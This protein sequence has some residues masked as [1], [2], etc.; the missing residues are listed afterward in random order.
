MSP[1]SW[2][3]RKC[4]DERIPFSSAHEYL[5]GILGTMPCEE[6]G[7]CSAS[8]RWKGLTQDGNPTVDVIH[9]TSALAHVP[10][11]IEDAN[12]IFDERPDFTESFNV[13]E[14]ERFRRSMNSLLRRR[15]DEDL[16]W[17][18]LI[19]SVRSNDEELLSKF[20]QVFDDNL[21][22]SELFG[23][24]YVHGRTPA[25]GRAMSGGMN[26]THNR[27][28][29]H[30]GR[31][32]VVLDEG[33]T[34]RCILHRPA[35][36]SARC[37]IGLDAFPA[38][39]MWELNTGL[40]LR[41]DSV[42][43]DEVRRQ[44]RRD[45]R[46]L[47]V[48]QVGTAVNYVTSGWKSP[49]QR[50]KS[51]AIIGEL[52]EMYGAEFRTA[53][54]SK[55]VERSV[56]EILSEAGIKGAETLYY[57][58]LRSNN[59]FEGERV[60]LL[61]GVIDPGDEYVLDMLALAGLEARPETIEGNRAQGRGFEGPDSRTARGFL[62]AIRESS[63]AQGIGRYARNPDSDSSGATVYVWTNVIPRQ[64]VDEVVSGVGSEVTELMRAIE[65]YIREKS[66]VT[67]R[68]VQNGI[69]V[70]EDHTVGSVSKKHVL[71]VFGRLEEQGI[72]VIHKEAGAYGADLC[73]YVSGELEREVDLGVR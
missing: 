62:D 49:A 2:F 37:V 70:P 18:S 9:A 51:K 16:T 33:N 45:E 12:V 20:E 48:R 41:S 64:L 23:E 52:R 53:I 39:R 38:K 69:E 40:S 50:R 10:W 24:E 6:N 59:D 25:I 58:N 47:E 32:S 73:E 55:S 57:G 14:H 67:A 35:L 4:H 17:T 36:E 56:Q 65:R 27:L 1:S 34:I 19:H 29:G 60:G 44:W 68:Q 61:L 3:D 63:V 7:N 13:E 54:T 43:S 71:D 22:Q 5:R 66:P 31:T 72:V 42:L 30:N 21:K 11:L 28:T 8:E 15:S 26:T 46:S